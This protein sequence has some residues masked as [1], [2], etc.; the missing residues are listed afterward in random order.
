MAKCSTRQFHTFSTQCATRPNITHCIYRIK[1][2]WTSVHAYTHTVARKYAQHAKHS[3]AIVA[4]VF[5]CGFAQGLLEQNHTRKPPKMKR[6]NGSMK[7]WT[8]GRMDRASYR[9]ASQ[10]LKR[11]KVHRLFKCIA[12]SVLVKNHAGVHSGNPKM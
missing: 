9:G 7:Q 1:F 10:H 5:A 2:P 6:C 3:L 8:D 12:L 11:M 4:F